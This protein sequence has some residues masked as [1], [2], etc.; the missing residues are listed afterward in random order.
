MPDEAVEASGAPMP[1]TSTPPAIAAYLR[2]SIIALAIGPV[3][4]APGRALTTYDVLGPF[5]RFHSERHVPLLG[6]LPMVRT[7]GSHL[8]CLTPV[9][10]AVV[11]QHRHCRLSP[12]APIAYRRGALLVAAAV[13]LLDL[14]I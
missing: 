9:L 4:G 8:A 3:A 10:V 2:A 6:A 7:I 5:A 1:M 11:V 12:D 13:V 14:L